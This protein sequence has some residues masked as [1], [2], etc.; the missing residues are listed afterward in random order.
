MT[1]STSALSA[2]VATLVVICETPGVELAVDVV[3]VPVRA[4]PVAAVGDA[5]TLAAADGDAAGVSDG[6]AAD[7]PSAAGEPVAEGVVPDGPHAIDVMRAAL[8]TE[9]KNM[10]LMGPVGRKGRAK[11]TTAWSLH[12]VCVC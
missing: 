6:L 5:M 7:V 11:V 4:V 1:A 9:A 8:V 2:S 3:Q 10:D 12:R